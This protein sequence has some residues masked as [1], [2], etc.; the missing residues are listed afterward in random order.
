MDFLKR[1]N[2]DCIVSLV[3]VVIILVVV[4]VRTGS[5]EYNTFVAKEKQATDQQSA[6][7]SEEDFSHKETDTT[8]TLERADAEKVIVVADTANIR[9]DAGTEYSVVSSGKKGEIF[10]T[11]GETKEA[12]NG[13]IWYEIY[14][15][16]TGD[17]TGWISSKVVDLQ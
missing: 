17:D 1:L 2:K 6:D 4:F 12:S 15:N 3:T 10:S 7:Q 9:S 13:R 16:D 14:L 11:T 8:D 5:P